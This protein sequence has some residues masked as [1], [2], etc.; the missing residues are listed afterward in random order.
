MF[1]FL[2]GNLEVWLAL[3]Y[4]LE[5]TSI[6]KIRLNLSSLFEATVVGVQ[7][8]TCLGEQSYQHD[9]SSMCK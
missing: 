3:E 8:L 2:L 4:I 5:S 9:G 6:E 7:H 1:F